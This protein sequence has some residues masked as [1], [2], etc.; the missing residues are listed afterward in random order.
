MHTFSPDV[1]CPHARC[2]ISPRDEAAALVCVCA[3]VW[4]S[5][6]VVGTI[7]VQAGRA[8]SDVTLYVTQRVIDT[9]G[10]RGNSHSPAAGGLIKS[11][12]YL[13]G[14]WLDAGATVCRSSGPHRQLELQSG[15]ASITEI[16]TLV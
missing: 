15:A 16:Y 13:I 1:P 8:S 12:F 4:V 10:G 5:T 14:Q 7:T 11:L 6:T 3:C 2:T 9:V